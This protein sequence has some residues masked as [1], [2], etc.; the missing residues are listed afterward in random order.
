MWPYVVEPD[1]NLGG[2]TPDLWQGK[3]LGGG[4]AVNAM[5][6]CR[7]AAS[8][9]DEWAQISGNRGLAWD[10]ILES[11]KA[12]T[13]WA[14][15]P[16]TSYSQPVNATSFGNGP[17]EISRQRRLLTFDEPFADKLVSELGLPIVD[18]VSGGGIGVSQG[19]ESIRVSNRTRSYATNTFGYLAATRPNFELRTRAWVSKV[20]FQGRTARNVTYTD[21]GAQQQQQHTVAADEIVLAA[22]A[23]NNPQLLML[24]GVGPAQMLRQLD[25]PVVLDS[26]QVGR[27]LS[28]HHMAI[29]QYEA[30]SNVDTSWQ[31]QQNHTRYAMAEQ[32]YDANGAGLLGMQ[33]GD[34]GG[35]LRVPDSVF[36]GLGHFHTSLPPDRP[37]LMYNYAATPFLTAPNVSL[38]AG[39]VALV[40][41]EGKG[42]V[43]INSSDHRRPP[44]VHANYYGSPADRAAITYGYRQ[45]RSFMRSP[46]L[47]RFLVREIT[48]GD[49]VDSDEQYWAAIQESSRS[50]HHPVGS[51]AIGSVLDANWRVK[52]LQGIRVV[53]SSSVPTIATCPIQST[54]YAIGHRA[55][56]DIAAADGLNISSQV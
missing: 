18:D 37:Q 53:G 2:R 52:G 13:H 47:S 32:G 55:A 14:E 9:F 56:V 33:N 24:S 28:D 48:P 39:F 11:F 12:T 23:L 43:S 15:E 17:L 30:Q 51:T 31:W 20:G 54:V 46:E 10:S 3:A 27:N 4:T 22:G 1:A 8:V 40:Q 26:P 49:G 50:W 44:Q 7:G 38:I 36:D 21:T 25:I 6:Y 34:V 19:L 45:L 29:L 35:G 42:F 5:L 41:P 16:S